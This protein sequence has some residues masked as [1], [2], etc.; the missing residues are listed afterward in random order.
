M[1]ER[2]GSGDRRH[3]KA[4]PLP[5][6]QRQRR[7]HPFYPPADFADGI[8]VLGSGLEI[9]NRDRIVWLH[10]FLGACDWWIVEYERHSGIAYGYVNL[11]DPH[12]AEWGD[13]DLPEIEEVS[14]GP[15]R[16]VVERDLHWTPRRAGDCAGWWDA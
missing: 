5:E 10:Y 4:A 8:P 9:D 14:V 13:I 1:I 11:G 2:R 12:N 7:G 6:V 15:L 16:A 3:R